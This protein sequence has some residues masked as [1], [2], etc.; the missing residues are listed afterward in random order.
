MVKLGFMLE[1]KGLQAHPDKT[2]YIVCKGNK[3]DVARIEK[4]LKM[5]PITFNKFTMQRAAAEGEGE[6]PG[7]DPS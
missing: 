6:V 2:C 4:E 7:A 5:N 3:K 1:D